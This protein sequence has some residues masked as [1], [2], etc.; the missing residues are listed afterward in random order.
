M[1][2]QSNTSTKKGNT[3]SIPV[4]FHEGGGE[5]VQTKPT[6]KWWVLLLPE[7]R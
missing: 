7:R 4:D 6:P 1:T 3:E 5:S 2:L